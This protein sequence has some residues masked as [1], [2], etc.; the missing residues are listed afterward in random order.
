MQWY[1]LFKIINREIVGKVDNQADSSRLFNSS[2]YLSEPAPSYLPIP[3]FKL[4]YHAKR[5]D[6][7]QTVMTTNLHPLISQKLLDILRKFKT[8]PTSSPLPTKL[9]GKKGE[10]YPYYVYIQQADFEATDY[11]RSIFCKPA[12]LDEN[13]EPAIC[14]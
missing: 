5:T 1:A 10:T 4:H 6:L 13:Y 9:I 11:A 7:I 14:A 3:D 8:V 2:K 12:G